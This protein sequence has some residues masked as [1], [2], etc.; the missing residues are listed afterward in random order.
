MYLQYQVFALWD[1]LCTMYYGILIYPR[2]AWFINILIFFCITEVARGQ[3]GDQAVAFL[4]AP[5]PVAG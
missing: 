2:F 3:G 4:F 5:I 1:F